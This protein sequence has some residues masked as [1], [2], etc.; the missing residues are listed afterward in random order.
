[1]KKTLLLTLWIV[2]AGLV[3]CRAETLVALYSN[4]RLR[5]F[6]SDTPETFSKNVT[7]TGIPAGEAVVALDYR[8]S[9]A[10][11]VVTREGTSVRLYQVDPN[12]GVATRDP[13]MFSGWPGTGLGFDFVG[14]DKGPF[15]D[16]FLVSDSDRLQGIGTEGVASPDQT[17]AYDNTTSDGDPVDQHAGDNPAIAALAFSNSFPESQATVLYG[18]DATPNSL[19]VVN[20]LTGQLDTVGPLGVATG[21]RCGFDWLPSE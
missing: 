5:F 11:W 8:P 17:V 20:R 19:V 14:T 15:G 10:L 12:S 1:M 3:P 4:N 6:D 7:I 9:G 16:A 2:A 13:Y 21:T 18:I